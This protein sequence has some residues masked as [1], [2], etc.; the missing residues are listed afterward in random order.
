M[1][2]DPSDQSLAAK[3]VLSSKSVTVKPGK[4]AKILVAIGAKASVVPS[5]T[6]GAD[7]FSFYEFSG[8]VVL[9]APGSTLRVPYLLVPRS[10]SKV[11]AS[12]SSHAHPWYK[13]H[14]AKGS[15]GKGYVDKDDK[16]SVTLTNK[17]GAYAANAD[18]YNEVSATRAIFPR[19]GRHGHGPACRRCAVLRGRRRPAPGLRG[20]H[21]QAVVERGAERVR[22]AGRHQR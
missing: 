1:S 20:E 7:E 4:T 11:A 17:G 5:S 14:P 16:K 8:D 9:T 19:N 13:E 2:A 15:K 3:V 21:P 18:F 6:A 22:R 12:D 10:T